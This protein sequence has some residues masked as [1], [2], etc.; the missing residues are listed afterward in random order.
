MFE[1]ERKIKSLLKEKN[2]T[3]K[4]FC[5]KIEMSDAGLY[6]IF[7]RNSI[8]TN[9]LF[10]ICEVLEVHISYFFDGQ[11]NLTEKNKIYIL[12]LCKNKYPELNP[13]SIIQLAENYFNSD[14]E[15]LINL[16]IDQLLIDID[17]YKKIKDNFK[18]AYLIDVN[19][20][21]RTQFDDYICNLEI[22]EFEKQHFVILDK[23][24]FIKYTLNENIIKQ[25]AVDLYPFI[26][27]INSFIEF[28]KNQTFKYKII[29]TPKGKKIVKE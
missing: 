19:E 24:K 21:F 26:Y 23:E 20:K 25:N 10:K 7:K 12:D 2:L 3:L 11:N 8:E 17:Y 18:F 5:S 15:K 27:E 6:K 9:L 29:D 4:E 1:I 28:L 16:F 13:N 14:V 22:I